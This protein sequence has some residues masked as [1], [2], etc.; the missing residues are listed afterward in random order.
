MCPPDYLSDG[1]V[2]FLVQL[3]YRLYNLPGGQ[4][5]NREL[6]ICVAALLT[7]YPASMVQPMASFRKCLD[8]HKRWAREWLYEGDLERDFIC[9]LGE[10]QAA[11][12]T[13][14]VEVEM[15]FRK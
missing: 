4:E 12:R 14:S 11:A 5:P 6:R 7:D 1:Q 2:S 13:L 15:D 9:I 8:E 3:Y 10:I